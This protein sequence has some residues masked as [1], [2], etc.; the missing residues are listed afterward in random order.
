MNTSKGFSIIIFSV[1]FLVFG[2]RIV[3]STDESGNVIYHT[4]F[5]NS[6]D[7]SAWEGLSP[8][9]LRSDHAPGGGNY[10]IFVSGGCTIPHASLTLEKTDVDRYVKVSFYGKN[11]LNGGDVAVFPGEEFDH[12]L[13]CIVRDSIWENYQSDESI[14]WPAG[15]G[16]TI[17]MNS[18]GFVAGAMLIDEMTVFESK[19][20]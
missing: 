10:S 2:C 15:E 16:L 5:E 6:A 7:L 9:N 13:E 20:Q 17:W 3:D 1:L 18:G 4:S 14:F 11:I 12:C 19:P 8:E